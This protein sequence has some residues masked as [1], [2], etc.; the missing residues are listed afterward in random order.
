MAPRQDDADELCERQASSGIDGLDKILR[1]GFPRGEMHLVQGASGTGKTTLALQFLLAGVRA[2]EAGL[3]ITLSQTRRGLQA[4]ARSHG[5]SLDG[6]AVHDLSLGDITEQLAAVQTVLHTA[7]V[8]LGELT[9]RMR[10]AVE[11]ARP[12]RVVIDSIGVL[13]LLAGSRSRL[14]REIMA[15][16]QFLAG[17]GC[18]ALFIGEVPSGSALDCHDS[19]AFQGLAASVLHLEHRTPDYGEVRRRL[20]VLK[21]RGVPFQSGHHD[22]RIR[23]GG[24]AVYPRLGERVPEEYAE[25]RQIRS[26]LA[27]LDQLL[28]G[29]LEHGTTCLLIGPAGAGKST[30]AS[31]YALAAARIGEAGAIFLLEERPETFT[32]RARSVK[33]DLQ[34]HL[35]SG[36][37]A[38]EQMSTPDITP[39]EF[40]HRVRGAVEHSGARLVVI[41]SLMGYFNV[42]TD[43]SML[44]VQM[45]ELLN[46]LNRRG[47]LT[48]L[49]TSSEWL[50]GIGSRQV[51]DMSYLSDSII[52]LQ[53]FEA[54]GGIRR[55]LA[56][57]KKRQGEHDTSIRELCISPDGVRVGTEP[58]RH[59][60]SIL[61]GDPVPAGSGR[62]QDGRG[63]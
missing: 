16:R 60:R 23:T 52:V 48:I 28:G 31:V 40:A 58:L 29:G 36:R 47:V 30:L 49:T 43:I 21:V 3:Y 35:D 42:M 27:P 57:V 39:G 34:P 10:Q 8:E 32:A 6:V 55:C 44:A 22:F 18:T 25:F 24:L 12:P 59:L 11:H 50:L 4:I 13:G 19:V 14:H 46:F 56:A 5:W 63:G 38:I 37:L 9:R 45:H 17:Y 62:R 2:G 54:E 51:V 7:D 15:L 26:G 53:M 33:L 41:D 1:G 61:S 20:Q